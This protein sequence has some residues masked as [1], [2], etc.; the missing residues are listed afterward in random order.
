VSLVEHV[1]ARDL[2]AA[3]ES[4]GGGVLAQGLLGPEDLQA[5]IDELARAS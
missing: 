2:A 4:T 5:I 3:I 1:W